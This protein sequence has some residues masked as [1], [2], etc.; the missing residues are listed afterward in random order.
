[1]GKIEKKRLRQGGQRYAGMRTSRKNQLF[2]PCTTSREMRFR[3]KLP[4][5]WQ[6]ANSEN[7]TA[8]FIAEKRCRHL[9]QR[10]GQNPNALTTCSPTPLR[11][12][13]RHFSLRQNG[14]SKMTPPTPSES[15][16]YAKMFRVAITSA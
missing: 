15:R 7:L 6:C 3:S 13:R 5:R 9:V 4:Q 14:H 8:T 10:H 1:L 12:D 11:L 16:A 2:H